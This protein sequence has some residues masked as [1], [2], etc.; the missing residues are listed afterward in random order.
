[1]NLLRAFLLTVMGISTGAVGPIPYAPAPN[2]AYFP[3]LWYLEGLATNTTRYAFDI[4]ARSAWSLS[5]GAGVTIAI[6]DIGVDL[7]HPEL[8]N[9]ANAAL[10]FNFANETPN[11]HAVLE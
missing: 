6:V 3:S 11:G 10:H 4:N 8:T 5:R 9:Q 2:D 7:T 1:M